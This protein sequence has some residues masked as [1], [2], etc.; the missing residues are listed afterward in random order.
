MDHR[1]IT[2]PPAD[3]ALTRSDL[4]PLEERHTRV[5]EATTL[6]LRRLSVSCAQLQRVILQSRAL[7]GRLVRQAPRDS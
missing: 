3:G 1:G 2:Q 6:S 7:R 5:V 4:L